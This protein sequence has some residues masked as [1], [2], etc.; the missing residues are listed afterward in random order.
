MDTSPCK[1]TVPE[2]TVPALQ[3]VVGMLIWIDIAG[4]D[5]ASV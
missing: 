3:L 5:K 4:Q 1:D 2:I